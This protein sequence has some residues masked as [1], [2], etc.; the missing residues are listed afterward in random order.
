MAR[1]KIR[2]CLYSGLFVFTLLSA[3]LLYSWYIP[4]AVTHRVHS[5]SSA[6]Q[7][8]KVLY[9]GNSLTYYFDSPGSFCKIYRLIHKDAQ[10]A[11][12]S[13]TGPGYT[14]LE[15]LSDRTT[16]AALRKTKWDYVILQEGTQSAFGRPHESRYAHRRFVNL[17]RE[18]GGKP[19]IL[20]FPADKGHFY[21][22]GRLS[23]H[24]RSVGRELSAQ[25]I[26][27]GDV[28]FFSQL[29]RPELDL[30]DSDEHHPGQK[31]AL[32]YAALA[33][34]SVGNF[35]SGDLLSKTSD[36]ESGLSEVFTKEQAAMVK[37][38]SQVLSE[39]EKD[40][41]NSPVYTEASDDGVSTIGEYWLRRKMYDRVIALYKQESEAAAKIFGTSARPALGS[42][43]LNLADA[44]VKQQTDSSQRVDKA[45]L[46]SACANL[47]KAKDIYK[48]SGNVDS[49]SVS[50]AEGYLRDLQ[51]KYGLPEGK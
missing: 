29:R 40:G 51:L 35:S 4:K 21:W 27:Y 42:C 12:E 22:Q 44:I 5:A 38:V 25:V 11:V 16:L 14:L 31:G 24:F 17:I 34:Q 48:R 20:M 33:A 13:A 32:L 49:N 8:V 47:R 41:V 46:A 19:L 9:I 3:L 23:Q 45:A 30:Y 1:S 7:A 28:I 50:D 26:P 15:H 10:L 43:Y 36:S 37:E 39:W 18:N 2:I 6:A